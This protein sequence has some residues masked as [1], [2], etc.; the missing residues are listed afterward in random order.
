METEASTCPTFRIETV[1]CKANQYDTQR[2]VEALGALGW[3]QAARDEPA[4][5]CIV[6]TCTVT[7]RSDRKCRQIASRLVRE[8]PGAQVFVVGCGAEACPEEFARIRGVSGVYP[9]ARW[10]E[11]LRAIAGARSTVD[12]LLEGDFGITGCAGRARAL[13]K[14]QDGCDR[15]CSYCIVPHVRGA[16]RSN[17]LPE[18]RQEAERLAAAGFKEIVITGIHLGYYGR[19]LGSKIG[20]ADAVRA[21]AD[22]PEVERVRLSSVKAD[23]VGA[24]LLEAMPHPSVCPHLHVPLQSGDDEVLR[25]M[26]RGCSTARFVETV[27]A[28]RAAL[29]NPAIT[30]DVIVGFPGETEEQFRNTVSLCRDIGFARIHIFPFSPRQ[31][32]AAARMNGRP[33]HQTVRSRV[34]VLERLAAELARRWAAGF[35]GRVVRV[36]CEEACEADRLAGYTDR[37]VRALIQG[38][39]QY[40]GRLTRV[41]CTGSEMGTILGEIVPGASGSL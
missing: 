13:L 3:C 37:Y 16:P 36:L 5:L 35:V 26:R 15:F 33:E 41:R 29:D 7:G 23:E 2:I 34:G 38:S 8:H 40:V 10:R 4:S 17:P 24:E 21:V 14:I 11:M 9:R 39:E 28:A 27:E 6:N 20:L 31:G 25:R 1:G 30:T 19:D 18:V 32:T 12:E 22:V